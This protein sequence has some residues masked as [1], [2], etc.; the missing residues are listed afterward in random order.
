[1]RPAHTLPNQVAGLAAAIYGQAV[2]P[3]HS[4]AVTTPASTPPALLDTTYVAC[5]EAKN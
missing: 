2:A 5:G 3:G 4:T 1:M